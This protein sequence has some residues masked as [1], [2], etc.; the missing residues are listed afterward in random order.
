MSRETVGLIAATPAAPGSTR[1]EPAF[2]W[3]EV[4]A[5]FEQIKNID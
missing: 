3:G 4:I 5:C 2:W 1:Q